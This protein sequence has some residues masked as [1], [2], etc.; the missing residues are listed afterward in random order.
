[1]FNFSLLL[2][3]FCLI[4]SL[5]LFN[6]YFIYLLF[7]SFIYL[8]CSLRNTR[9]K[10]LSGGSWQSFTLISFCPKSGINNILSSKGYWK[11]MIK[12]QIYMPM[13]EA[14]GSIYRGFPWQ[15]R[16]VFFVRFWPS[17]IS[18]MSLLDDTLHEGFFNFF[19]LHFVNP[20]W[21]SSGHDFTIPFF[22]WWFRCPFPPSSLS[23][24]KDSF[25]KRRK[26]R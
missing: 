9:P 24:R 2:L 25:H 26:K 18:H 15:S 7:N 13:N 23:P 4:I 16:V 20:T 5:C 11:F 17:C 22:V 3:L 19:C 21:Q 14:R 1:M 10:A 8:T 6:F 12:N